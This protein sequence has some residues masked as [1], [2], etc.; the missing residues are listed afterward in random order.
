MSP[1]R[2]LPAS[3]TQ[4]SFLRCTRHVHIALG[5]KLWFNNIAES[6][7]IHFKG[8]LKI[9]LCTYIRKFLWVSDSTLDVLIS[10]QPELLSNVK[11]IYE[12]TTF[13]VS[14]NDC[15]IEEREKSLLL[16][17]TYRL[18]NLLRS[19]HSECTHVS[20]VSSRNFWNITWIKNI[21][22]LHQPLSRCRI[23]L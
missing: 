11:R 5:H 12:L 1:S 20:L 9:F 13:W 23:K 10:L 17:C 15:E 7:F 4:V 16:G 22:C 3:F 19:Q 18:R 2:H 14:K 8:N 21:T 6:E